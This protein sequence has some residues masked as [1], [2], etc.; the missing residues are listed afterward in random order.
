M[1]NHCNKSVRSYL[2]FIMNLS[3]LSKLS[4]A[5]RVSGI[6]Q[7]SLMYRDTKDPCVIWDEKRNFWHLYGSGGNSITEQWQILHAVSQNMEGPWTELPPVML[8]GIAPTPHTCA[9]GIIVDE[10]GFH[11]FVQTEFMGPE[12]KIHYLHS[13]DGQNFHHVNI[14]V[15]SLANTN[16]ASMYDPHPAIITN[17]QGQ[18]EYYLTF[19][20]GP[21]TGYGKPV[22]GDIFLVKS[23]TNS[24]KGPWK[25]LG[26]ILDH[27]NVPHHNQHDFEDYEWGLEGAQL[28]QLGNNKF[29]LNVVC[30]LPQGAR[31]TRQRVFFALATSPQGPFTSVGPVLNPLPNDFESGENGH[32]AGFLRDNKLH[33]FYQSRPNA[34]DA[35][36]RFGMA[37]FEELR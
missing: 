25:R 27:N 6:Y 2:I 11:M 20:A 37:L 10:N 19:S 5:K 16:Q 17:A 13:T 9:P 4:P 36:W 30:F 23:K 28:I 29:L 12:G 21:D 7:P 14:A 31:G 33:L 1:H 15:E 35:K 26:S 34:P 3:N 22:H 24:W 32:A 18:K 8:H